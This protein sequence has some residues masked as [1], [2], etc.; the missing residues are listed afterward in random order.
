M[1]RSNHPYLRAEAAVG[2]PCARR[3]GGKFRAS[4]AAVRNRGEEGFTLIEMALTVTIMAVVFAMTTPVVMM[5]FDLNGDVQTTYTAV[6]QVILASEEITQYMHEA[7]APCPSGSTAT[8]C[9]TVAFGASTQSSLTFY[10]NT[11]NANGPSEVVIAIS[12]ST[13]TVKIYAPTAGTC[14]FNGSTTTACTYTGSPHLL[15][16]VTGLSDLIPFT[17]VPTTGASTCDGSNASSTP[18]SVQCADSTSNPIAAVYMTLQLATSGKSEP[19]GYQTLA[20]ALAPS[21]NGTVG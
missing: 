16:T 13:M 5:Y 3:L 11:N 17:Y 15:N 21:Y 4:V 1:T 8:G 14:P 10:V 6:N 19:N 9:S 18:P 7:V 2:W 12:G 20:Y